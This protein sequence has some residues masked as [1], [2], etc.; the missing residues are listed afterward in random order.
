MNTD[1][2]DD[3]LVQV[4]DEQDDYVQ[5]LGVDNEGVN[6]DAEIVTLDID[7]GDSV[8]IDIDSDFGGDD[9]VDDV[10]DAMTE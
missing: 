2:L 8:F 10:P 6:E 9:T 5:I 4:Y 3:S 1:L 7:G